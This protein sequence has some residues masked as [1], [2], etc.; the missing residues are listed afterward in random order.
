M[1]LSSGAGGLFA[2]HFVV[3]SVSGL[4]RISSVTFC[5]GSPSPESILKPENPS[6]NIFLSL[7]SA[8]VYCI[9]LFYFPLNPWF[10]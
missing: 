3:L 4:P 7:H 6:L 1:L 10:S 2:L 8:H 5:D 9:A